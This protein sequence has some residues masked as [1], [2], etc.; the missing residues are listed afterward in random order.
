MIQTATVQNELLKS[1]VLNIPG[2][3]PVT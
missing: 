1:V 3:G 2:G